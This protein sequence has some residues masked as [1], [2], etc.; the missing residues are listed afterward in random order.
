MPSNVVQRSC[1]HNPT[2]G[3]IWGSMRHEQETA[4]RMSYS[5]G[6]RTFYRVTAMKVQ[7]SCY[8]MEVW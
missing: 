7:T 5:V 4:I 6:L 8:P 3:C 2:T 1:Q